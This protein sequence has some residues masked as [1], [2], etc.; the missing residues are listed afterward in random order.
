MERELNVVEKEFNFDLTIEAT[1]NT[2]RELGIVENLLQGAEINN[3]N[4][5]EIA[6]YSI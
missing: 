5:N 1:T 3:S 6:N 2:D 4:G